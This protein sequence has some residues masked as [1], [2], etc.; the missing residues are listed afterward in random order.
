MAEPSKGTESFTNEDKYTWFI[1]NEADCVDSLDTFEE[2]FDESTDCSDISNLI[3]NDVDEADQGN[4]L[5]LFNSQI[6][7]DCDRAISALKRK[8][9]KSPPET[10]VAALSP[11][12]E[13]I[14]LSPQRLIKR[15]LFEDS[16]IAEDEA[17]NAVV[18][19]DNLTIENGGS[20]SSFRSASEEILL[21]SNKRAKLF[22]KVQEFY[23]VSFAELTRSFKSN[24]TLSDNWVVFTYAAAVEVL[25]G[26][27]HLLQQHCLYLQLAQFDF[28]GLFL[29]QFKHAK[30]RETV[31][32]LFCN[33]LNI[34]DCQM[35]CEPPKCRSTPAALYFYKQIITEKA[36]SFG[37]LPDWVSK[38]TQINHQIA[39]QAEAFELSKMIQWAY[40]NQLTEEAAIAYEYAL[41]AGE[42]VNAAAFLKSNSQVKYVKDCSAMV[43]LYFRQEMRNMTMSQWIYKCC[44][45]CDGEED[46]KVIASFLKFQQINVVEFLCALRLFF[47]KVPKK[48]CIVIYGEPDTGKSYFCFSFVKFLRG[49][50][51]SYMNKSSHFWIQPLLDCKV[52]F[53]DDATY[54]CWSFIDANMRNALDG[55]PMCVD[56]KHKAP[57]QYNLPPLLITSNV[58][59]LKEESLKYLHSRITCFKFP[60][61]LPFDSHNNPLYKFTDQVWKS[62]FLRLG[63]QLDLQ[64]DD[65]HESERPERTFRCTA[66]CSDDSL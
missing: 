15:R 6:T 11:R 4:S 28:C 66:R 5:A 46:W 29:L 60:N 22:S 45:E 1:V 14:S 55:N 56:S 23:G 52:G 36:Y 39:S 27:K 31:T 3:D 50:V 54:P 33:I 32:K 63:K 20:Q 57:Q 19:V 51:V 17:A 62:F 35:L 8:Y 24:K 40:D 10:N 13:A 53:L 25:E 18:Q 42:D 38:H 49:K 64:D 26:S 43:K 12:L 34:E 9:M 65:E 59:V 30:S 7:E 37:T 47:K 61:K 16:G 44:K 58:D 21:C 2:L 41:L 48:T